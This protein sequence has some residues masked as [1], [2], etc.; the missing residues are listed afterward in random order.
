MIHNWLELGGIYV[1]PAVSLCCQE[2]VVFQEFLPTPPYSS[3]HCVDRQISPR[4]N[5]TK[6]RA[7]AVFR[8]DSAR[9]KR[10]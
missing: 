2:R 10:V 9:V 6:S 7:K 5:K 3:L 1:L 4:Y 8:A